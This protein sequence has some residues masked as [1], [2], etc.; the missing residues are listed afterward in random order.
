MNVDS[1]KIKML[2]EHYGK[3]KGYPQKSYL[4]KFAEDFELNYNQ[5]NAYTR[6]QQVIG[7]K[8]IHILM[9][10]FPD[11]NLNWLLKDDYNM[12]V[13]EEISKVS[14]SDP[15][16]SPQIVDELYKRVE[17]LNIKMKEINKISKV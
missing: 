13:T 4:M 11:L 10:V 15:K 8:I 17:V 9:E 3:L 1:E 14:E 2:I 12:F 16:Y 5:W 6:G 7:L